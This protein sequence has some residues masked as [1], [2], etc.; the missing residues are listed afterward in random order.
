MKRKLLI[1]GASG[2]L[3]WHLCELAKQKWEVYS[4]Y[5][6]HF[7]KIPD[8]KIVKVDLTDFQELKSIFN[9]IKPDAV[10]HTA[11]QS[12]PNYCQLHPQE[13]YKINVGVSCNIAGLCADNYLPLVFTSSDL[14]FDGLNPVYKETDQVSPINIYGEQKVAAE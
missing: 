5:H 1:T 12:Q 11:A 9:D 8:I 3:G 2:F 13:A 10:I 7:I 14:V 4:T 6:T